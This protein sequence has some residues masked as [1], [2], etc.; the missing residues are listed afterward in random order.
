MKNSSSVQHLVPVRSQP[1]VVAPLLVPRYSKPRRLQVVHELGCILQLE[2]EAALERELVVGVDSGWLIIIIRIY[3]DNEGPLVQ[4]SLQL[5]LQ[6]RPERLLVSRRR[7]RHG[8]MRRYGRDRDALGREL[9]ANK[10]WAD[11]VGRRRAGQSLEVL[12]QPDLHSS[13]AVFRRRSRESVVVVQVLAARI[14]KTGLL[15]TCQLDV[16][17]DEEVFYELRT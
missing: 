5:L 10:A 3:E 7:G 4:G 8:S 6:R 1:D 16:I 15:N 12:V 9:S 14:R 11:S 2:R 13:E 17:I